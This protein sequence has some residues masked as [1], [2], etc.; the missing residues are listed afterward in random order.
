[1]R[2]R[3]LICERRKDGQANALIGHHALLVTWAM[4][5]HIGPMS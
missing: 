5:R 2:D 1:M 3:G 4:N